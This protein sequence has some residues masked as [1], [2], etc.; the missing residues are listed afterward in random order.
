MEAIVL[1]LFCCTLLGCLMLHQSI[2]IALFLGFLLFFGYGLLRGYPA[3]AMAVMSLEGILTV[4]NILITF[5]LIGMLTAT[6]RAAGT[7]P[8]IICYSA[9]LIHPLIFLPVVFLLNC[10]VSFLTG[11]SF[12]T[13]ATMGV[14]AM[15]MART[16]DASLFLT[17][18]AILSGLYFGDRCSP[19]STSALLVSELTRTDIYDNIRQMMRIAVVPFLLTV[20]L[21]LL[22]GL[23]GTHS[24]PAPD[25]RAMFGSALQLR[26]PA[27]IPALVIM[28]L[29]LLR[30]KTKRTMAISIL[31]AIPV[32]LWLQ[33]MNLADILG[34]LVFGYHSPDPAVAALL[35]GGGIVSM[36]RVAVI[37]CL[38]SSYAGI[39]KGTRMLDSLKAQIASLGNK[40]SAFGGVLLV[41]VVTSAI[42]CNQ[43]LSIMLTNQLCED[44][45]PDNRQR[46]IALEDAPELVAPLIPWSIA[47]AV[48]LATIGADSICLL[49]ACY[50]YLVP[51]WHLLK[52]S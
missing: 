24:G 14:I 46:A 19:V 50:L 22:A 25:I 6:W 8:V 21:Y 38:S 10:L 41:S 31:T 2:L 33:H 13:A 37:V 5:L 15:T 39:F 40:M 35:N 28:V 48:P 23:T 44:L 30:M 26:W 27:L 52:H 43:T 34:L 36:I 51:L 7:I 29:S 20:V 4:R 45:M 47:G 18:G 17:G 42:S 32:C 16:M 12:G 9:P 11:T 3:K 1:I 49:A